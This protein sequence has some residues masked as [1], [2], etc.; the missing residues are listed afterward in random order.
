MMSDND[1]HKDH[2]DRLRKKLYSDDGDTLEPHELLEVLLYSVYT[3]KD[4]NPIA[5]A[6]IKRFGTI[7]N[8]FEA[9]QKELM[10]VPGVGK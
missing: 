10:S 7:Y 4:T 2:R 9:D 6:L 3:Q 5:R 8:V 1:L